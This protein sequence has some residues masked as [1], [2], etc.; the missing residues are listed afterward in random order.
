MGNG[1]AWFE[2]GMGNKQGFVEERNLGQ[3]CL[4]KKNLNKEKNADDVD[5]DNND[6]VIGILYSFIIF[7]KLSACSIIFE[8]S[9]LIHLSLF[10]T[11]GW[12]ISDL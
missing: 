12:F 1:L 4:E 9:Q 3:T 6:D 8:N 5:D 11:L 7:R 2:T 10:I